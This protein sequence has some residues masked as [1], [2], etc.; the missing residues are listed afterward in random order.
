MNPGILLRQTISN[1]SP[2][3]IAPEADRRQA[4]VAI[5]IW[6]KEDTINLLY[7]IRSQ[8]DGDPWSGHIAFP[9]GRIEPDDDG[10]QAA[11]E[12][13]AIEEVGLHLLPENAIG[14]LDDLT[15]HIHKVHVAGFVYVLPQEP[16]LSL[17]HEI[18]KA[19]WIPLDMLMDTARYITVDISGVWGNRRVPA[20]NICGAGHPVLWGI[21]YR[22]TAQILACLG[23]LLP[24]GAN[25][26]IPD[27]IEPG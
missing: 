5:P 26:Q 1:R 22:F 23:Y 7:L 12:R 27:I 17:N 11:A 19:F 6:E 8:Q 13:E 20:I 21:T 14:R 24:G 2:K 18:Q 10:P 15:T 16:V 3:L 25:A 9:G 4:A